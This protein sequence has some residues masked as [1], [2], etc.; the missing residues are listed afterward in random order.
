MEH[1]TEMELA[2]LVSGS[3]SDPLRSGLAEHAGRCPECMD[4]LLACMTSERL[5][6][7]KDVVPGAGDSSEGEVP[8][9]RVIPGLLHGA[10]AAE[11]MRA[12][13]SRP[14]ARLR[15]VPLPGKLETI[16]DAHRV[17]RDIQAA[18]ETSDRKDP[19]LPWAADATVSGLKTSFPVLASED[20][21]LQVRFRRP[22]EAG[23]LRAYV[24]A[25]E[26][27]IPPGTR[28]LLSTRGLS[29]LIEEDGT[30]DL[31]G[32]EVADLGAGVLEVG[33]REIEE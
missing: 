20:G 30:A 19:Q 15:L 17:D 29:F 7:P 14:C 31:P 25:Q 5:V 9:D 13:G 22:T 18:N 33:L 8:T 16:L 11:H 21:R 10:F 26:G 3:G 1:L 12:A 27:E 2:M 28:L 6:E 32:V 4:R 23:P 24:L